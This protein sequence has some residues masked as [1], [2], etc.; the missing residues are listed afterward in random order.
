M[1]VLLR[2]ALA[3]WP[4][5]ASAQ[6]VDGMFASGAIGAVLDGWHSAAAAANE[7]K[8]FS[9]FSPDAVFLGTDGTERWTL[10]EF[11]KFAHPY[12]AKGKAWKDR[13]ASRRTGFSTR[14]KPA[15]WSNT[16]RVRTAKSSA[17]SATT[18][19]AKS[20]PTS[21]TTSAFTRSFNPHDVIGLIHRRRVSVLVCV[22]KILG[23]LRDHV[24]R[25]F[26]E[27][28]VAPPPGSRNRRLR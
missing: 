16:S 24:L 18:R 11:R 15:A 7:E 2:I 20:C 26:P 3:V 1:K 13:T 21:R 14:M 4:A 6:T 25:T 17:S 28:A 9:Y 5:V 22:P 10:A 27:A 19:K 8:Y 23:V 12:F